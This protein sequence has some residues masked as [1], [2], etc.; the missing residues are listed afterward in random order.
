M[1]GAETRIEPRISIQQEYPSTA[2]NPRYWPSMKRSIRNWIWRAGAGSIVICSMERDYAATDPAP[3]T[4]AIPPRTASPPLSATVS[5]TWRTFEISSQ[6]RSRRRPRTGN[7]RQACDRRSPKR[8][9]V[10]QR[11][12]H[13][14]GFRPV[15]FNASS[16]G[17]AVP[18][19][20][21]GPPT[22]EKVPRRFAGSA[23]CWARPHCSTWRRTAAW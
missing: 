22:H 3:W 23:W 7:E 13:Q 21:V 17:A 18:C 6:P 1:V 4:R 2:G 20:R 11:E 15:S 16:L 5:G 8:T 10:L 9:Y 12:V 19:H 14:P